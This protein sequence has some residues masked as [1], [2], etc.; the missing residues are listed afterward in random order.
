MTV[1]ESE[2]SFVA[3]EAQIASEIKENSETKNALRAEISLAT[4]SLAQIDSVDTSTLKKL[5]LE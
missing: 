2:T 1:T 3:A 5:L 4:T